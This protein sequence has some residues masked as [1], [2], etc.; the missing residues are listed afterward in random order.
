[1]KDLMKLVHL[2]DLHI[3]PALAETRLLHAA[4][5][6]NAEKPDVVVITGDVVS[7]GPVEKMIVAYTRARDF[8]SWLVAPMVLS[9]PGNHDLY[10]KG[11]VEHN[12]YR[13]LW[14]AEESFTANLPGAYI[15][16]I[17]SGRQTDAD[18]VAAVP[19]VRARRAFEAAAAYIRRGDVDPQ[20][21]KAIDMSIQEADL[22]DIRILA[23]HHHLL[24]VY[25]PVYKTS[26]NFDMVTNAADI[27]EALRRNRFDLVLN[28]HKH[29][30]QLNTLNGVHHL[31]GGSLFLDLPPGEENSYNVIDVGEQLTI[32]VVY[33]S[34][35]RRRVLHCGPNPKFF[36]G[37]HA[38]Q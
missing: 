29:M 11:F 34:T 26:Y 37:R 36:G 22:D 1:M 21:V 16:G 33:P 13:Y 25:N 31:T 18:D 27:L 10:D 3:T 8:R 20:A 23:L 38:T 12:L 6:I 9:V 28:G 5:I 14:A 17:N 32:E 15:V 19:D 4:S 2:T 24:P 30:V 7:R 35:A